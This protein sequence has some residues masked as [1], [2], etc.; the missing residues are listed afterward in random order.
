MAGNAPSELP[1]LLRVH[2]HNTLNSFGVL[3]FQISGFH[4]N[5]RSA[6]FPADRFE[7][8]RTRYTEFEEGHEFSLE[9]NRD[10]TELQNDLRDAALLERDVVD[11]TVA[12]SSDPSLHEKIKSLLSFTD[13]AACAT[14]SD[15]PKIMMG[16]SHQL[17]PVVHYENTLRAERRL[18]LPTRLQLLGVPYTD[19][20]EQHRSLKAIPNLVFYLA[21]EKRLKTD[22]KVDRIP[23]ARG[24]PFFDAVRKA[25]SWPVNRYLILIDPKSAVESTVEASGTTCNIFNVRVVIDEVVKL[26]ARGID[27]ATITILTP[28]VAQLS[29]YVI[30]RTLAVE[31]L[32]RRIALHARR[33]KPFSWRKLTAISCPSAV[34]CKA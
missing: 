30:A 33:P 23:K 17:S 4:P 5:G 20:T 24:R 34:R 21:Y 19:L 31:Q 7:K 29:A 6:K 3:I 16:D 22:P 2:G 25:Y 13:E 11:T 9:L 8:F 10:F 14:D 28:Y 1:K 12:G 15:I 32:D 26:L 18:S 27:P